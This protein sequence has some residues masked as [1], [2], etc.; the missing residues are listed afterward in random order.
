MLQ[1]GDFP[2]GVIHPQ[3]QLHR[4]LG[5]EEQDAGGGPGDLQLLACTRLHSALLDQQALDIIGSQHR[6]GVCSATAVQIN[7][8]T[9]AVVL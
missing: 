1:E 4:V 8:F 9:A 7:I 5:G 2:L 6:P 3:Q